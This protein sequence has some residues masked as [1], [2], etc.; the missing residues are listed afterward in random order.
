MCVCVRVR[1]VDFYTKPGW[2]ADVYGHLVLS[3]IHLYLLLSVC[4]YI[5]HVWVYVCV[6]VL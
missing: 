1:S 3:H 4:V 6:R 2:Y 5:V